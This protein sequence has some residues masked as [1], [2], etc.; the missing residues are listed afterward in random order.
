MNRVLLWLLHSGVEVRGALQR[1]PRGRLINRRLG[2]FVHDRLSLRSTHHRWF[3]SWF[4]R[5][6]CHSRELSVLLHNCLRKSLQV[7][8]AGSSCAANRHFFALHS[9]LPGDYWPS[10]WLS[11]CLFT[12]LHRSMRNGP[13]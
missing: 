7:R 8:M 1:R 5:L 10:I 9:Y 13:R 2:I 12:S 3:P 4:N 6:C 11:T